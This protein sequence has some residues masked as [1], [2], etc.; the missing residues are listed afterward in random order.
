MHPWPSK[1]VKGENWDVLYNTQSAG[2]DVISNVDGAIV[3]TN[4][5]IIKIT[6]S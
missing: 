1:V 3:W 5:L 4:E 6:N 2:L